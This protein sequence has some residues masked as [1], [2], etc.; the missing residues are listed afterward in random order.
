MRGSDATACA[1]GPPTVGHVCVT[2]S[3]RY[4]N[5][6]VVVVAYKTG[7]HLHSRWWEGGDDDC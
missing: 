3:E 4:D 5:G 6:A 2:T 7:P 1:I